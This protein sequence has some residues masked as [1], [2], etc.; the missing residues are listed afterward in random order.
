LRPRHLLLLLDNCEH[1]LDGVAE[2]TS[3]LLAGCPALQVLAT[4]REPLRMRAE[5]VFPVPPLA[6]D[7]GVAGDE[8]APGPAVVLFAQR[9]RA[10]QPVFTLDEASRPVVTE[11]CRRLDGLPLAIELAAAWVRVLPPAALLERLAQRVLDVPGGLRDLPARQQTMREAI[12]WSDAL[13]DESEQALFR[14]LAV[15]VGGFSVA[16]AAAVCAMDEPA[17]LERIGSLV[18]KSLVR[19]EGDPGGEPRYAMLETIR[20]F[21]LERLS[22]SGRD[23]DARSRHADWC[24]AFAERAGPQ[25]KGPDAAVWLE[26][27]ERDYANL[28]AALTWLLEERDGLRL[29][30]L[31]GALWRFWHEHAYYSEGRHWL[32]AALEL[33]DEAPATDRLRLL[34]GSGVLA[35]YQADAAY[36]RQMHE[37][38][39]ALAQEVGDRATEAF[40]LGNLAVHAAESG[41]F[42]LAT[43]RYEASLTAAREVGDPGPVVLALHNLAHQD[44]EHGQAALALPRLEEALAVAREH[45]LRW[46]L[47]FILVALGMTTTDLGDPVRAIGFFQESIRL[48]Q[49]RGNLGDVIDGM[50]GLVRLAAVTGQA[51]LAARLFGA[52]AALRET[53]GAP[54]APSEQ[55]VFEPIWN[56]LQEALGED[57]FAAAWAAGQ[58][59]S[60]EE[61]L[62]AALAIDLGGADTVAPGGAPPPPLHGLSKREA[63]V[64]RLLAAGKRNRE[65]GDVLFISAATAARHVANIYAKLGI[66]SRAEATAYAHRHGLL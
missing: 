23:I 15:F 61:A 57:G 2:L 34:S 21:G 46:A 7:D 14:E 43:A 59:L 37:Q 18:A 25:A 28:R 58:M 42:A 5:H 17:T 20:A 10:V 24:L 13:L 63:E 65:I 19:F 56:G 9:A 32:A 66:D 60:R 4:S 12:A 52:T 16:A 11:I 38:A 31:A 40:V 55:L 1:L 3:R 30:R 27:L 44:W 29:A 26:A 8:E 54:M 47:P 45:R 53:L 39:L 49:V 64:L 62:A 35:W 51:E 33:G 50:E 41:D 22:A 6:I 36:S 48:A